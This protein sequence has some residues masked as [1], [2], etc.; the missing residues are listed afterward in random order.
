MDGRFPG[1]HSSADESHP[2]AGILL[3]RSPF[4][5]IS[6]FGLSERVPYLLLGTAGMGGQRIDE[7]KNSNIETNLE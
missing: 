4:Q 3:H 6:P 2:P 7:H 1:S 5:Q